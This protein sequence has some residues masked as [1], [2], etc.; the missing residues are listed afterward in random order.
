MN[1]TEED[2]VRVQAETEEV[3]ARLAVAFLAGHGPGDAAGSLGG[4]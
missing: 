3:E 2:R 4:S 1:V